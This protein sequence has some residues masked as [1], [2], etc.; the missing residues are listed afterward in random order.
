MTKSKLLISIFLVLVL[1][2]VFV[3]FNR[4]GRL[5][6]VSSTDLEGAE[7]SSAETKSSV[8]SSG[9]VHK[10]TLLDI[11][12]SPDQ[13]SVK[14]GETLEF[15][16]K[17]PFKHDVYVVRTVNR[18][19]VIVAA[20]SIESQETISFQLDEEGVFDLYCTIHGGMEGKISTTSYFVPDEQEIAKY[21]KA[22]GTIPPIVKEG[23]DI[24]WGKGQCYRCH[25]VA[26]RG[27]GERGPNLQNIGLRSGSRAKDRGLS[28]GTDYIVQSIL[29]PSAYVVEGFS[30][31]MPDVYLPPIGL[32]AEEITK[33]VTYLQSQGGE[34]DEWLV[35]IDE[36]A[37]VKEVP[38]N[39]YAQGD[40][41]RG[42][43]VFE[44]QDCLKCHTVGNKK[45]IAPGPEFTELG[46]YRDWRWISK[47]I[48][49]P[50]DEI[51]ANWR[52]GFVYLKNG[53]S[54]DGVIKKKSS[55]EVIVQ[56]EEDVFRTIP[57]DEVEEV[58]YSTL[59]RMPSDISKYTNNKEFSDLIAYLVSL[60]GPHPE[61]E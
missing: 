2:G 43:K 49:E 7:K 54:V 4:G 16:N 24:F 50:N 46:S 32:D 34:V 58:Q 53:T 31:D 26:D 23:E 13:I 19:I 59:S 21:E 3:L 30:E 52:N 36:E 25:M 56:L 35:D 1:G 28:T 12:F 6:N 8:A 29:E 9:T 39:P 33:I 18:N 10:I 42:S 40:P 44:T 15:T 61:N 11:E 38:P 55:K 27:T 60:K 41:T 5:E 17:D 20:T 48:L 57:A 47:S 37:L 45:S 51:G 14:K 22:K